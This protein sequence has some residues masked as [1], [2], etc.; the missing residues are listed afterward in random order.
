MQLVGK[1][2]LVTGGTRG[3]GAATA[4]ALAREGADVAIVGRNIDAEA[5]ATRDAILKL[6]RRCE[7]LRAD[8][9]KA[10]EASRCV[11]ETE[12]K[13]GP[14]AVLVHSAGGPVNGGLF[15]LTPETWQ[16]AFDL[17]VHAVFHLSRAVI[18]AMQ[19]KKEGAIVLISSVAGMRGFHTNV[20]YQVVKGALPQFARALA[21]E[22]APDNIRVNCVA[23]GIIRTA[24]HANMSAE[25]KKI[26]L[27]TR[28]PLRR[29]GTPEQVAEAIVL[30]VKNDYITGETVT[31]DGGLTM[32]MA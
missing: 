32:R 29:E 31:I 12:L 16:S 20:A 8:C 5:T 4:I 17:H 30:L 14:I 18:P 1:I 23:P 28:V 9:G 11:K 13:L 3:I 15:D 24:F 27:E 6:G 25:Q 21:R 7:I 19:A 10:A 2:A 26:N 22:F